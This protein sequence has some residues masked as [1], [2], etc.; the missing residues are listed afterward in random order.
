[1][2]IYSRLRRG[3]VTISIIKAWAKRQGIDI[4]ERSLYRDLREI[5]ESIMP[6][7]ERLV[8]M[9][10]EKNKK[11]WKLEF[12]KSQKSLSEFDLNSYFL[13]RNFAPL[14]LL[15]SR[16]SSLTKLQSIFYQWQSK[17]HFER[18]SAIS[19]KLLV[20]SHFYE[21]PFTEGFSETLQD[22]IWAVQNQRKLW[23]LDI[24]FDYTSS[25]APMSKPLLVQPL[26]I[27]YHRGCVFLACIT[28]DNHCLVI[29]ISQIYA[30]ELSNDLFDASTVITVLEKELLNRFGVTENIDCAVYHIE[31]EF[32]ENTGRFVS[33]HYWHPSQLFIQ[34]ES[35]N[36]IMKLECGINR[37]LVGWIFQWMSNARVI[38]PKILRDMVMQKL[39]DIG[40]IY[41]DEVPLL[42]NNSFLSE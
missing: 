35:G 19:D 40:T 14:S 21:E 7:G 10:G 5:E 28:A 20:S 22:C 32:S 39:A 29:G 37:E 17:S 3:P 8:V 25:V 24:K 16:S 27:I 6:E 38:K 4:S 33:N 12:S 13:L 23:L 1:M 2:R 18:Y 31:I 11:T 26:K 36:Y 42:S 41:L 9:V 34:L 30:Y 15:S